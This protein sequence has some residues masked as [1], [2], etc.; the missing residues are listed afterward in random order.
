MPL[1]C[2]VVVFFHLVVTKRT[3]G[4]NYPDAISSLYY[5]FCLLF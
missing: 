4:S 3:D 2:W 1:A 5:E